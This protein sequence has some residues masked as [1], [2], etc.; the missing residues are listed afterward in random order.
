MRLGLGVSVGA[1]SQA[2]ASQMSAIVPVTNGMTLD[3]T[4]SS[5]GQSQ[6]TLASVTMAS[7]KI[8]MQA[9]S[10]DS[11]IILEQ[12]GPSRGLIIYIFNG[13]L[14]FQCGGGITPG[15]GPDRAYIEHAITEPVQIIEFS[16]STIHDKAA[17]Y[18]NGVLVGT[19]TFDDAAIAG[20][21]PGGLGQCYVKVPA[22]FG[23]WTADGSGVFTGTI[24]DAEIY[25]DEVTPDIL[26]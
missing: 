4:W 14:Y 15:P 3:G 25:L 21:G 9:A 6:T 23:G 20:T 13:T 5:V 10:S 24:N 26:S 8:C 12:G 7:V 1:Y 11:G 17:L 16:A 22:N 19:D 18:V 2:L